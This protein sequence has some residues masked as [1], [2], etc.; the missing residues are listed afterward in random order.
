MSFGSCQ[1]KPDSSLVDL[2]L[3]AIL[4]LLREKRDQEEPP[5]GDDPI[6]SAPGQS[7][8]DSHPT[9]SGTRDKFLCMVVMI[10]V[11]FSY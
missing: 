2:R 5:E 8:A 1:V 6:D 4:P 3:P 9:S 11:S 10:H 7:A